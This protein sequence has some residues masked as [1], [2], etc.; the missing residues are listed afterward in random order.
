MSFLPNSFWGK[1]QL[2]S[3]CRKMRIRYAIMIGVQ[4]W[5]LSFGD[6]PNADGLRFESPI[7]DQIFDWSVGLRCSI[8]EPSR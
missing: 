7:A 2:D 6:M 5:I 3:P 1:H 4:P 8:Q